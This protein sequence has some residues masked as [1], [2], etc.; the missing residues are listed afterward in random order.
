MAI[1]VVLLLTAFILGIML[2]PTLG[3]DTVIRTLWEQALG[4]EASDPVAHSIVWQ[5]RLPRVLLS[6]VV[7][8]ALTTSGTVL[9]ALVRN[10]LAD[11]FILGI[12]S[13][14]SV[15]ATVV[16]L[17]GAFASFGLWALSVGSVAGAL[18]AMAIVFLVALEAGQLTLNRL[19]L[20]GVALSAV[21][22]A[23]SSLLPF[24]ASPQAAQAVM[25]WL[26]GSFA[27][28]SWEQLWL[29]SLSLSLAGA[30][31]YL[32]GH[33]RGL[34]AISVGAQTA[35]SVGAGVQRLRRSVYSS[36]R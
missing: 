23:I 6:A 4:R 12:S 18:V 19:I 21:F 13:G 2:G 33:A 1:G 28:A 35:T 20:S 32:L 36:P 11:P 25:F 31:I 29:P 7:C 5:I 9:P 27:R 8:A 14:A 15:G 22:S 24:E 16:L 30:V 26:L 34:N 17:F 3:P 10:P